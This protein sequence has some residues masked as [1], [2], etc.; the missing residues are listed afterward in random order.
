MNR[1]AMRQAVAEFKPDLVFQ[2]DHLRSE[3]PG[4]FPEN[5]V[6]VCWIQDHLQNLMTATAGASVTPRDFVLVENGQMY[7]DKFSYPARQCIYLNKATR[8]PEIPKSWEQ[9]GDEIVFV[10]NCSHDPQQLVEKLW[11]Q[12]EDVK[13][14]AVTRDIC[15]RMLK[16]YAD[17]G[18]ICT[19]VELDAALDAVE[20]QHG[21]RAGVGTQRDVFLHALWHP[22]NDTLYRQ[23]TLRWAVQAAQR[24]KI[25]LGLY[26]NGWEKNAEFSDHARGY[27]KYGSEL[28]ELTRRTRVNLHIVPFSCVHQRLL[29]GIACGGFFMIRDHPANHLAADMRGFLDKHLPANIITTDAV[30]RNLSGDLLAEFDAILTRYRRLNS[31]GDPVARVRS[32]VHLGLTTRL[33]HLD[34]VSF[35]SADEFATKLADLLAVEELRAKT[36]SDQRKFVERYFTYE[37]NLKRIVGTIHQLIVTESEPRAIAA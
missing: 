12:I 18:S 22:L 30:R 25:S 4:L 16:L 33:P 26:G 5:L 36:T 14:Q 31:S 19:L 1:I 20:Q 6:S 37:S 29:D 28:E 23:Q 9:T 35:S 24:M 15:E 7:Q 2:I 34:A 17:G 13:V 21:V 10:S 11:R 3:Y 27:A 8:L 32:A